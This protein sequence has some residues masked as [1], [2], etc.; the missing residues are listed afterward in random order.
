MLCQNCGKNEVNFRYTQ[1]IN[2]V[3]KEMALCDKCAKK[4]GLESLDFS[5]EIEDLFNMSFA[6]SF[7]PSFARTNML[8]SRNLGTI[9][10]NDIFNNPF[11]EEVSQEPEQI[12]TTSSLSDTEKQDVLKDIENATKK[13]KQENK[14]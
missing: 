1:V 7:L 10:N 2:G 13:N 3:K 14:K 11:F 4:L 12:E 9:F 5:R 6:E 8:G